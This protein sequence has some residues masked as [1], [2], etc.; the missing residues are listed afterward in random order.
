L[1]IVV[2]H[3]TR[4]QQGYFCV[5]GLDVNT[6]EHVRPVLPGQRLPTSLLK[7]Y[8][9][10]FDMGVIVELGAVNATPQ[11]PDVEDYVFERAKLR[12]AGTDDPGKF[13]RRL[14]QVARTRLRD[15]FGDA[16]IPRGAS[17]CAVDVGKGDASLGCLAPSEPPSLYVRSRPGRSDQIRMRVSDG[18]FNLDLGVTD[19]RL[20][21]AD[22]VTPNTE[23]VRR[24]AKR[25]QGGSET[26]LSVGLTR[27]YASS[28]DF[29]P[30][31]WLQVNNVHLKDNP[32][33]QL[34]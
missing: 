26:V 10:P 16:L 23:I 3:L 12:A 2:N 31:H 25:L 15:I 1:K 8:G 19:I 14:Q 6:H 4:M 28:P 9:G 29:S 32:L 18:Y 17:S 11:R 13:W 33:W 34:G 5:A 22:H 24:V 20:Y 21:G 30:V 27:A 7:R